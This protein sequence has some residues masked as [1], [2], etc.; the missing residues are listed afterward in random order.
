MNLVVTITHYI[1]FKR[2][3]KN[4]FY[5]VIHIGNYTSVQSK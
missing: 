3:C 1:D 2:T 4:F 5:G